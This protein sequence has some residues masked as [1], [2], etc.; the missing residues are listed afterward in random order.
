MDELEKELLASEA[1]ISTVAMRHSIST[2]E[3]ERL[4]KIYCIDQ[5]AKE[6]T[7][8]H[9][10]QYKEH[11]VNWIGTQLKKDGKHENNKPIT[12]NQLVE[13]VGKGLTKFSD[14]EIQ[15]DKTWKHK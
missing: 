14:Y 15:P 4:V 10:K 3:V 7:G 12:Y 5:K 1:W 8:L 11:C 9:L 13:M 6:N 2:A